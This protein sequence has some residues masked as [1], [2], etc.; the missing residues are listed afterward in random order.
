MIVR[1]PIG[2]V[3]G[4]TFIAGFACQMSPT[5]VLT[6]GED[7]TPKSFFEHFALQMVS[8]LALIYVLS[9]KGL[10]FFDAYRTDSDLVLL[11]FD[12]ERILQKIGKSFDNGEYVVFL[13]AESPATG[14]NFSGKCCGCFI[15]K[16]AKDGKLQGFLAVEDVKKHQR[17]VTQLIE[18]WPGL[19]LPPVPIW[20]FE[21]TRH[22][23]A[24]ALWGGEE[25]DNVNNIYL[26]PNV[27]DFSS[28][29]N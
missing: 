18:E 9:P 1:E 3:E 21:A 19:P 25:K 12:S 22:P 24:V 20:A 7:L 13:V 27:K 5:S 26:L 28:D 6:I 10:Y 16:S 11:S 8:R 23:A 17:E 15:E 29:S 4:S 14:E 2:L